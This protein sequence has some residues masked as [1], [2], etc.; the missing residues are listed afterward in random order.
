MLGMFLL[1]GMVLGF[2]M[3]TYLLLMNY[4]EFCMEGLYALLT[5]K[6]DFK[7]EMNHISQDKIDEEE[8][9]DWEEDYLDLFSNYE[10]KEE[11]KDLVEKDIKN[12]D[13]IST[14]GGSIEKEQTLVR[15]EKKRG[16][17]MADLFQT[18]IE[19]LKL[20]VLIGENEVQKMLVSDLTLDFT[21]Q[22]VRNIDASIQ[23][24]T[25]EVITDKVI[26][27]GT[28]HKQIF[29]V[30]QDNVVQ[31]Q[32]ED[33]PFSLFVDIPG[34]QPGMD[35]DINPIIEDIKVQLLQGGTVLH[36]KVILKLDV[37]VEE[38]QQLFVETGE[39]TLSLVDRVIGENENQTMI[40]SEIDLDIPA[41]KI[42]DIVAKIQDLEI[43]VIDNKVI[44]QGVLHKQIFFIG[45]DNVEY[46]QAE[47][48]AFSHFVD[49]P[50]AQPG[51]DVQVHPN[52]EHIKD[53]LI[54]Q[55]T[56]LAQEVVV[57]FF[58]K[59]T[60]QVQLNIAAGNKVVRLK[61]V[62]GE[63]TKQI[64]SESTL[65]LD[66]P[67]IKVKD[68]DVSIVDVETQIITNKVIIQG[69]IH[70]QIYFIG[71]D[72][73]E[74][75]QAEDVP[76]ST[77]VEVPGVAPNIANAIVKPEIEFV[78]PI[79]SATGEELTQKVVVELFVKAFQDPPVIRSIAVVSVPP[80]EV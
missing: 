8:A 79:L 68:I 73:V 9:K 71:E 39:G 50:G 2:M 22:K 11:K 24:L 51:M 33:V 21:A 7:F 14:K 63:N 78:K 28:V 20:P 59:V 70:K 4:E 77:F 60:Q 57:S 26:V 10:A 69:T 80:Y 38:I 5:E 29:Y 76:F 36:Q 40:E 3:S 62:L 12:I 31:H 16:D 1:T 74:Y 54:N 30:T 75:H 64:L 48:V 42:T 66:I 53:E 34:V 56:T 25:Y 45:E 41:I 37:L 67:A 52:I 49:L 32:A 17:N 58:V 46:H 55:G 61:D 35:V 13:E 23:D 19:L 15:P 27:Q 65:T 43:E 6:Y 47:D 18:N 44:I 72:N